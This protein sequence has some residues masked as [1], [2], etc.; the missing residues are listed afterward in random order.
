MSS[1][2][3]GDC[4]PPN[5]RPSASAASTPGHVPEG[6][7]QSDRH[8]RGL[9]GD[10]APQAWP[11][12]PAPRRGTTRDTKPIPGASRAQPAGWQLCGGI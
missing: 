5:A 1:L 3:S 8:W 2:A 10:L 4:V 12:P 11:P 6:R 7:F 9:F